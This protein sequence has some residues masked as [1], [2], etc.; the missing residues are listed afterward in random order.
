MKPA[1][2]PRWKAWPAE[3][4]P[5]SRPLNARLRTFCAANLT[6]SFIPSEICRMRRR[7]F[8]LRPI[9]RRLKWNRCAQD[10]REPVA[11]K[12]MANHLQ[13][14]R[15]ILEEIHAKPSLRK[16]ICFQASWK[17]HLPL[18]VRCRLFGGSEFLK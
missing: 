1:R 12:S 5:F 11:S 17:D 14:T 18:A 4:F 13:P 16:N 2:R 9:S 3:S 7:V 15:K 6:G 8:R 10:P